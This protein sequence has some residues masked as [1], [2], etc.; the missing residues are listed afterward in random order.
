MLSS[1][2]TSEDS[3]YGCQSQFNTTSD[4]PTPV[5]LPL[6]NTKPAPGHS[7]SLDPSKNNISFMCLNVCGL[8]N[9]LGQIDFK[10]Q[11]SKYDVLSFCEI[12][13]DDADIDFFTSEFDNLG[14][15]VFIQNRKN[16]AVRK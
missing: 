9:R 3:S 11:L 7:Y 4:P 15:I 8:K 14:F 6:C 12:N 16:L 10:N 2:H 5:N 13:A 1:H